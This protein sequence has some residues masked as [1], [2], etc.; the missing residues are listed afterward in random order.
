MLLQEG[1]DSPAA[2]DNFAKSQA[3]PMGPY[4]LMDYVGIDTVVHSLEYYSK[5]L[6]PDYGKCTYYNLVII[7][8]I[9]FD[10]WHYED[11]NVNSQIRLNL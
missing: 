3:L 1:V 6:S 10:S 7:I 9:Y 4:E 8:S 2:I 11:T 5:T